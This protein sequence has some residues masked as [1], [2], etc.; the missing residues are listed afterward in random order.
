M[1]LRRR[2]RSI[3]LVFPGKDVGKILVVA[4]RFSVGRLML[5]AEVA[6]TGFVAGEGIDAHELAEFQE[7]CHAAG[8][9][10][11]LIERFT[12]ARHPD[13]APEMRA[14]LR[15]PRES[16]AQPARVARHPAFVPE[17]EAQLAM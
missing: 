7:V 10:E 17:E 12:V 11:R 4:P 15:D 1:Q 2:D 3:S 6:A 13:L 8:A 14:H 16:F 9:F 5:F